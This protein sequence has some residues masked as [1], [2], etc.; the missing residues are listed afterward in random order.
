MRLALGAERRA[1]IGLVVRRALLITAIGIAAGLPVALAS[2]RIVGSM[3]FG[4]SGRDV[5]TVVGAC[6]ALIA[7][8]LA[9]AYLPARRAVAV[10]PV[11]SLRGD[12]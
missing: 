7:I 9:G 10:N 2:T 5:P 4:V 12:F 3:L 8:G 1:V 6:A 11:D